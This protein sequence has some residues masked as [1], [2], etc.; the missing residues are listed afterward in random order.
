[1]TLP[2][3]RNVSGLGLGGARIESGGQGVG[4]DSSQTAPGLVASLSIVTAEY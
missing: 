2:L 3:L 1:M 4:L